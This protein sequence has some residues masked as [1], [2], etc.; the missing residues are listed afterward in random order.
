MADGTG[1]PEVWW[2]RTVGGAR[3]G[4]PRDGELHQC[5]GRLED[6]M[7]IEPWDD[8]PNLADW[9]YVRDP[10]TP[11]TEDN[12]RVVHTFLYEREA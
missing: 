4:D 5:F 1:A 2:A 9:R 11:P 12:R 8:S 3:P 7:D 6:R 10:T